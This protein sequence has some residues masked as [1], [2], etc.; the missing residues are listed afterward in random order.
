[1]KRVGTGKQHLMLQFEAIPAYRTV[2]LTILACPTLRLERV[3]HGVGRSDGQF[4]M[5]ILGWPHGRLCEDLLR[6]HQDI[7]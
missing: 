6:M 7:S 1:M 2:A 3:P 4:K 5:T